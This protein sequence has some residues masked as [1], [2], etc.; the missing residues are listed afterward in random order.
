[1]LK[2][3]QYKASHYAVPHTSIYFL[4]LSSKK[5]LSEPYSG[6]THVMV[7][8]TAPRPGLGEIKGRF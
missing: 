4:E 2:G 5:F 8:Y 3:A 6:E 1:M 7:L